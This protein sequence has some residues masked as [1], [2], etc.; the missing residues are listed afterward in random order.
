MHTD[1]LPRQYDLMKPTLVALD[2]IGGSASLHEINDAV[3]EQE[4]WSEEMLA[5]RYSQSGVEDDTASA[6]LGA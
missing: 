4:G 2:Q 3:I 5:V 1:E 6:R